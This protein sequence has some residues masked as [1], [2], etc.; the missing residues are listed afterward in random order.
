MTPQQ[1]RMGGTVLIFFSVVIYMYAWYVEIE[2]A[3]SL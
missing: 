2:I 3:R 1:A